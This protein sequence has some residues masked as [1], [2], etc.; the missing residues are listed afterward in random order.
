MTQQHHYFAAT[1][2]SWAAGLTRAEAVAGA[3]RIAGDSI[4]K[5]NVK[6]NGGLYV[7]TCRVELPKDA[8]Y[9]IRNFQPRDVPISQGDAFL[10]QNIKGH[11]V[12]I[13]RPE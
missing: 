2:V 12:P 3:A 11:V 1:A 4:I 7:W 8:P 9:D 5:P 13:D 6:A 10:I